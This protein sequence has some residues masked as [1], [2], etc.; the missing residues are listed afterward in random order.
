MYPGKDRSKTWSRS[1][2]AWGAGSCSAPR[3]SRGRYSGAWPPWRASAERNRRGRASRSANERSS[4]GSTGASRTRTLPASWAS[5]S[6]P[7]RTTFTTSWRSSACAAAVK[8]PPRCAS[9]SPERPRRG[10]SLLP[11]PRRPHVLRH[12]IDDRV[13]HRP[14]RRL[15]IARREVELAR[16]NRDAAYPLSRPRTRAPHRATRLRRQKAHRQ[17]GPDRRFEMRRELTA[18]PAWGAW[19]GDL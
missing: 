12:D 18:E 7:S 19:I 1:W 3:K 8:Q 11:L 2:R 4:D 15:G 5:K 14:V 10:S 17:V 6:P 9:A 16:H 13:H